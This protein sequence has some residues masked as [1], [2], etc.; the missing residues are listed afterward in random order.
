MTHPRMT[1]PIPHKLKHYRNLGALFT[2][3]DDDGWK[4]IIT[5]VSWSNNKM[6]AKY[7]SYEGKCLIVVVWI[8][9]SFHC[10]L[11]GSPFTLGTD[12][13]PLEFLMESYQFIGTLAKWVLILHEYDFDIIHM[14]NRVNW[15]V[16]GLSR[17]PNSNEEDTTKAHW[18]GDVDL[19]AILKCNAFAY[20]CTLLGCD[21]DVL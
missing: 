1:I 12:H 4:F 17:N 8:V 5:Y 2:Q 9:S 13:Q 19:E 7:S 21:G 11:C 15:N 16:D 3:L 18:H 10:Y 14:A 6:E 20:L